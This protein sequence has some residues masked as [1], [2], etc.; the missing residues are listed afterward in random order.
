MIQI[1]FPPEVK[2]ALEQVRETLELASIQDVLRHLIGM[3]PGQTSYTD[4]EVATIRDRVM[5]CLSGA[6]QRKA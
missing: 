4:E 2:D 1:R 5:E 6:E 3:S